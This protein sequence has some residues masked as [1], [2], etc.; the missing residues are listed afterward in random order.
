MISSLRLPCSWS[1][2][3]R[4]PAQALIVMDSRKPFL[5]FTDGACEGEPPVA[6]CGGMVV[7]PEWGRPRFFGISAPSDAPDTALRRASG[8]SRGSEARLR[9]PR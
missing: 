6:T 5:V 4:L 1:I 8:S 3:S 9:L 7:V 2:S